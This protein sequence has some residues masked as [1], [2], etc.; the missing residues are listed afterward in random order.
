MSVLSEMIAEIGAIFAGSI[1]GSPLITV[2]V[3]YMMAIGIGLLSKMS[4]DGFLVTIILATIIAGTS[5]LPSNAVI[6]LT[7]IVGGILASLAAMR[8]IRH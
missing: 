6:G 8:L 3:I 7:M 1:F 2:G 4:F 5:F